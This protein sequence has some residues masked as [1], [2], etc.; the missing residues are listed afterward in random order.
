MAADNLRQAKLQGANL[1]GAH[2]EGANLREVNL[3]EANISGALFIDARNM[4]KDALATA[5]FFPKNGYQVGFASGPPIGLPDGV[6]P[7][8]RHCGEKKQKPK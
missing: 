1:T 5:C 7:P 2:M 6:D 4:A 8:T 3:K